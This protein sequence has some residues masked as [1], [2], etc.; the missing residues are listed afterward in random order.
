MRVLHILA[1]RPVGGVGSMLMEYNNRIN[2]DKVVFDAFIC[3]NTEPNKFD[4]NIIANGGK[5]YA[6]PAFSIK[7]IKTIKECFYKVL[8]EK[9]ID[10][11]H[12]HAINAGFVF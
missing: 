10:A 11:V 7:N 3:S 6:A 2:H 1:K 12:L 5:V 8:Q 9:K 4:A